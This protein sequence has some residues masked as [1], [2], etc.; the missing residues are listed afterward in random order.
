LYCA[1]VG[2]SEAPA[3]MGE[4]TS[5]VHH[6]AGGRCRWVEDGEEDKNK[7]LIHAN[8]NFIPEKSANIS[9]N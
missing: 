8:K 4:G 7:P 2:V 6:F 1:G 9:A 3:A 5:G